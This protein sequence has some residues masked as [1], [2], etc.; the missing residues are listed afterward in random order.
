MATT[1]KTAPQSRAVLR[2]IEAGCSATC[3]HCGEPVKFRAKVK[4]HQVICNVYINGKWDRVEHF[5]AE[6]YDLAAEPHG[7]AVDGGRPTRVGSIAPAQPSDET[8]AATSAA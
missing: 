1:T 4:C 5:H 6:C 7:E 8:S 3:S 2:T